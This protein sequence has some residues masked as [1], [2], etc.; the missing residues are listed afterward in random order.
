[1][2]V[3]KG[4]PLST[5]SANPASRAADGRIGAQME[6]MMTDPTHTANLTE[7]LAFRATN[8][9]YEDIPEPARALARQCILDYFGVAIA[10]ADDPLVRILLDEMAEAGGAPQACVIG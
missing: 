4:L 10:A 7:F 6:G 1:M 5:R 8:L 9:R 3:G 2:I